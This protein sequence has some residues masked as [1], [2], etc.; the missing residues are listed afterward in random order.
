[1]ETRVRLYSAFLDMEAFKRALSNAA[2]FLAMGLSPA[3]VAKGVELPLA[4]VEGLKAE[5]AKGQ[6]P[7]Q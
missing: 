4:V 6:P 1:M 3:D 7:L 2:N 5:G